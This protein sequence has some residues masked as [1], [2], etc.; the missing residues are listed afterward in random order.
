MQV[1]RFT[2]VENQKFKILVQRIKICNGSLFDDSRQL[3]FDV[4]KGAFNLHSVYSELWPYNQNTESININLSRPFQ[5]VR[6]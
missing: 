3:F 1:F 2:Q 4:E 6:I 5:V